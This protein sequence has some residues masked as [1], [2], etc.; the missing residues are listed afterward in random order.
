MTDWLHVAA[1]SWP[2]ASGGCAVLT[3]AHLARG[4]R[5][6]MWI[7]NVVWPLTILWA[8]PIGLYYYFKIGRL[9]AERVLLK[10]SGDTRSL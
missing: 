3:L 10:R 4:N 1:V 8:G 9:S 6:H 5:Q 7:M 2:I